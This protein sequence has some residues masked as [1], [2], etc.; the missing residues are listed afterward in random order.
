[1]TI[2]KSKVLR[3]FRLLVAAALLSSVLAI[4]AQAQTAATYKEP[5]YTEGELLI[6]VNRYIDAKSVGDAFSIQGLR[7]VELL[8]PDMNIWLYSYNDAGWTKEMR[9]GFLE[10]VRDHHGVLLAQFNHHVTMRSTIPN[11]PSFNQQY[12]HNNTGQSGGTIDAD[13]DSPEAWD[14][15][16][17][18]TTSTGDEIVVAIV[19]GGCDLAHPDIN[20]WKNIDEIPSNGY[21]R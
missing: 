12:C 7:P 16:T 3:S 18:G 10:D 11:D 21:R 5:T 17:G 4:S 6:Q 13:M 2:A 9:E 20:Y 19:D 8:S 15:T 1:M 14:I